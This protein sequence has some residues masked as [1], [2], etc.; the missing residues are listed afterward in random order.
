MEWYYE[1]FLVFISPFATLF[2]ICASILSAI[3]LYILRRIKKSNYDG[4]CIETLEDKYN[5]EKTYLF[6]A[7]ITL[8]FVGMISYGLPGIGE[9]TDI[10]FA[11]T[12]AIFLFFLY[13]NYNKSTRKAIFNI[14]RKNNIVFLSHIFGSGIYFFEELFTPFDIIPSATILWY[15]TFSIKREENKEVFLQKV[16]FYESPRELPPAE[17]AICCTPN[18]NETQR[19]LPSCI[20]NNNCIN[21]NKISLPP[22]Q[23]SGF[24]SAS[25]SKTSNKQP[26]SATENLTESLIKK[27]QSGDIKSILKLADIY[28]DKGNEKSINI[29]FKLLRYAA[30]Q[31]SYIAHARL[32]ILYLHKKYKFYNYELGVKHL[33]IAA[34]HIPQAKLIL[35]RLSLK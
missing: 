13:R 31:N 10:I 8:D 12:M 21:N 9:I 7:S 25:N 14:M 5:I 23:L 19:T 3:F 24:I 34:T 4:V 15:Y 18:I 2:I 29:A 26:S 32:G 22:Q 35:K 6:E 1:L 16:S 33:K 28:I 20:E 17:P 11:P 30:S 27:A